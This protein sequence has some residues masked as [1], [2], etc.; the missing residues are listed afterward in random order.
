[1]TGSQPK[2]DYSEIASYYDAARQLP[3]GTIEQWIQLIRDRGKLKRGSLCL[4]LGCGTGRFTI[5]IAE[6]TGARTVGAD[7]SQEML[8][9][10]ASKPGADAVW[11][12]RCDAHDLAFRSGA[13]QCIFMSL[14][15]H[16]VE[17]MEQTLRECYRALRRGGVCLIRTS[18]HEDMETMPVYRFFPRAWEID[19]NRL[20]AISVIED[21]MLCAGF[22][23]V[24]HEKVVQE[25]VAS[26]EAYLDKMRRKNISAL[27]LIS[28]EE[29]AEGLRRLEEHFE[30]V[31]EEAALAEV[32]SEQMTLVIGEK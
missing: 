24:A 14:L 18:A 17:D 23:H 12:V 26:A 21:S 2:A 20:P 11:W 6:R 29:F 1:M 25:L 13:F 28:D 9:E 16:H 32:A 27:T 22:R 30:S 7:L 19:R 5:P 8:A 4:D 15:L 3:G 31:G 10:A